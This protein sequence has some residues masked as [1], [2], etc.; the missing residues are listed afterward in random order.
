[1][2]LAAVVTPFCIGFGDVQTGVKLVVEIFVECHNNYWFKIYAPTPFQAF[3]IP[4]YNN[5]VNQIDNIYA[6]NIS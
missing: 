5:V 1:M 3:R 4:L 6:T 2:S